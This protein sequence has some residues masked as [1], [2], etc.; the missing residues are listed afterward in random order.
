MPIYRPFET[1]E[2]QNDWMA[3]SE[4]I[5]IKPFVKEI[6]N[7]PQWAEQVQNPFGGLLIDQ[8]GYVAVNSF[9]SVSR[10]LFLKQHQFI[11]SEFDHKKLKIHNSQCEYE[12]VES[13]GIIFCEGESA[14]SNSYF[15]W[16]PIRPM[17]GEVLE[18]EFD[19]IPEAIYNRGVYVVPNS[20]TH[21][22]VGATYNQS[23][24]VNGVT[25]EGRIELNTKLRALISIPYRVVDQRWGI[26]PTSPDRRPILGCHPEYKN[27]FIFNGL[28]TKGVSLAPHFSSLLAKHLTDGDEIT[29]EVNIQ[30]FYPLYSGSR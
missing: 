3:K 21:H 24:F 28:G 5:Q 29:K 13:K 4:S 26:R 22:N 11:E 20:G 12:D 1:I 19:E 18:I 14:R 30:R 9:L 10:K 6:C 15:H 27:V 23:P 7:T 2:E 8:S 17:K 25:E 16:V